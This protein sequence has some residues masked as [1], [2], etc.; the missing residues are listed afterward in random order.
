M[1]KN[2]EIIK[3]I[4][5]D[6]EISKDEKFIFFSIL[7]IINEVN[8]DEVEVSIASLL[9]ICNPI[10]KRKLLTILNSLETKG[11]FKI[12]KQ[13]GKINKYKITKSYLNNEYVHEVY[14]YEN[15]KSKVRTS[16][17]ISSSQNNTSNQING[18]QIDTSKQMATSQINTAFNYIN[19]DES[20][21]NKG[22]TNCH[23]SNQYYLKDYIYNNINNIYINIFNT[24]NNIN[25]NKEKVL[26]D[27]TKKVIYKALEIYKE[28]EIIKS[29]KNYKK[30]YI[31]QNHYYSYRW[32]LINFLSKPNGISR[33]MDNGDMWLEY[34][35]I[36]ESSNDEFMGVNE[37]DDFDIESYID[38]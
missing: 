8:K 4:F 3:Y 18:G 36:I 12:I 21:E 15:T 13:T 33:F 32:T 30:V 5:S 35:S 20:I 16:N 31:S 14:N 24:W 6:K 23:E 17:Q 10:G 19:D 28:E 25:I 27:Y 2:H 29:I 26:R 1:R 34:K 11:Y 7:S 38:I 9:D 37:L 22:F